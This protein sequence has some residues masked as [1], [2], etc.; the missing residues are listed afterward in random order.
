MH[1]IIRQG[2]MQRFEVH[3]AIRERMEALEQEVLEGRM[4]SFRA[5]RTLLEVYLN[6]TKGKSER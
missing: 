3:P 2:L 4:T 5:A 6:P 1:E